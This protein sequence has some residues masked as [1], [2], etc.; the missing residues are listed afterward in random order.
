MSTRA[1][2][3]PLRRIIALLGAN[4]DALAA[5]LVRG[6]GVVAGF[7]LT[8]VIARWYG[9]EANGIYALVS[10]SAVFLSIIAVGGLDMAVVREFSRAVASRMPLSRQAVTGVLVQGGGLAL[11]IGLIIAAFERQLLPRLIGP[12][13]LA[14]GAA[15]LAALIVIRALLRIMAAILRS[16]GRYSASQAIELFLYPAVTIGLLAL[17]WN[18][19]MAITGIL[20]AAVAAGTI[21]VLAGG[22]MVFNATSRSS[23][24]ITTSQFALFISALPMWG[25]AISQNLADWYGL[26]SLNQAGGAAETGIYRVAWQIASVIP[27]VS[28]SLLG[29]FTA[30]IAAAVHAADRAA[31]ARLARTATGLSLLVFAPLAVALALLA[32]PF[33]AVFGTEFVAG[34]DTLR[35]LVAGHLIVAAFGIS[36]QILVMAGHPRFNLIANLVTT[37]IVLASAP[38]AAREAGGLGLAALFGTLNAGKILLYFIAVRRLEN[39]NAFTG[40]LDQPR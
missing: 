7:G 34:A 2:S 12:A 35:V 8:F 1:A 3:S 21:A 5:L 15:I 19:A 17:F 32:E 11:V 40:K 24:A 28:I 26:V 9:P 29:T 33:L 25:M 38:I 36:G 23:A 37:A 27:L 4:R 18:D 30:Q 39:F 16:Q 10:Q 20:I 13:P 31:M 14:W 6:L 22:A